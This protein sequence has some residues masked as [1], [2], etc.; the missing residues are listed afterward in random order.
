MLTVPEIVNASS[1]PPVNDEQMGSKQKFWCRDDNGVLWLFKYPRHQI[2][3]GED[4]SEWVAAQ[5]AGRLGLP[6]AEVHLATYKGDR[7][8]V[9][10][11]FTD[12]RKR[13]SLVHGNELLVEFDPKYP[14]QQRMRV[15]KHTV[16]AILSALEWPVIGLPAGYV[17]I[18][19]VTCA[20]DLFAGYLLLDSVIGNTD[21]HHEN[22]AILVRA[23]VTSGPAAEL[24]P[25]FDH[26]SC[27]GREVPDHKRLIRLS[28]EREDLSITAYCD[29]TRSRIYRSASDAKSLR[30]IE[31]FQN[32]ASRRPEAG[33]AW[34]GVLASTPVSDLTAFVDLVPD[35]AISGPARRFAKRML[36]L[37]VERLTALP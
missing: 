20:A 25:T 7:G 16:Q 10:R 21:R 29:R 36:E 30:P 2:G 18:E 4:W 11:D 32:A 19:G 6:H 14:T 26:A 27:L 12:D 37:N 24:A 23:R 34:R 28:V 15:A 13:G 3:E 8:I 22:W 17:P 5:V 1:W 35:V 33:R 9:T 31:A